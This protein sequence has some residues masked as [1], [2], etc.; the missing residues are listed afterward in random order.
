[1]PPRLSELR[2]QAR[3]ESP[4]PRNSYELAIRNQFFTPRYVIEF[5]TDN[6]ASGW[7]WQTK[8]NK[9]GEALNLPE[10]AYGPDVIQDF[11][12][13][14]LRRH[15]DKPF[16][17]YYAMHLVHKPILRTPDT[18]DAISRQFHGGIYPPMGFDGDLARIE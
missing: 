1:M 9:N 13:D 17:L 18:E 8:Y 2:D 10:G 11:A 5:L 7:Y 3:K 12:F 16:F 14:F 4:A 15:K 6:T